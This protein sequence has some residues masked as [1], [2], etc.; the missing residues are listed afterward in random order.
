MQLQGPQGPGQP[1]AVVRDRPVKPGQAPSLQPPLISD[2]VVL[3]PVPVVTEPATA[4]P[5]AV[6]ERSASGPASPPSVLLDFA[7]GDIGERLL[8]SSPPAAAGPPLPMDPIEEAS[9][10]LTRRTVGWAGPPTEAAPL[11]QTHRRLIQAGIDFMDRVAPGYRERLDKLLE[12]DPDP[13]LRQRMDGLS[14][15]QMALYTQNGKLLSLPDDRLAPHEKSRKAELQKGLAGIQAEYDTAERQVDE[16]RYQNTSRAR[17]LCGHFLSRLRHEASAHDLSG[18]VQFGPGA[19]QDPQQR[20]SIRHWVNEFH[21]QTGLRAPSKLEFRHQEK[22]AKYQ[23][24]GDFIEMGE[25]FDKRLCMHEIA[26]RVE[27]RNPE[28]SLANKDF[29]RARARAAGRSTT[30]PTPLA[31]L[32]PGADYGKDEV[33][34]EDHFISPYVGKQY[35]DA[36]TEVLSVGLDHFASPDRLLQLYR[37]DPE[38]FFLVLGAI[39]RLDRNKEAW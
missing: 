27:Y 26:H 1:P 33:A 11:G 23:P 15:R 2:Q 35:G 19:P 8:S 9:G 20:E 13:A 10:R 38:H 3:G 7:A 16:L 18:T 4:A 22:R 24:D 36:A 25:G 28:I 21:H 6:N 32:S 34:L 29:V 30:E 5:P 39:S 37:R 17:D 31:R 12:E 14:N